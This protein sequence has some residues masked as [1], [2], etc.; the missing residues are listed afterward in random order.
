MQRLLGS[1]DGKVE[2][3]GKLTLGETH[4]QLIH[5]R[6]GLGRRTC[7]DNK[8]RGPE[9]QEKSDKIVKKSWEKKC[10]MGLT[11]QGENSPPA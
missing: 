1:G 3:L 4:S 5:I 8:N 6:L 7:A 9:A 10:G 2:N 11:E